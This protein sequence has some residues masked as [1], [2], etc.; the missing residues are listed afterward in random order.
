MR[1]YLAA[2]KQYAEFSGRAR[3]KEFWFFALFHFIVLFIL[4]GIEMIIMNATGLKIV[5]I[6][7]GIYM[8][9]SFIPGLAVSVRRLHDTGRSGWWIL[10][11]LVP[12]IGA[13]VFLVFMFMDSKFAENRYGPNPKRASY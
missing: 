7:S 3:R 4:Y 12:G 8:L 11:N 5:G 6:L 2:F 9:A 1:W 10:V 13:V